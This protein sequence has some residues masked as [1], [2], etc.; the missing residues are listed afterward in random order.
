M[1]P[2]Q[3]ATQRC[4]VWC[5]RN[6]KL[7]CEHSEALKEAQNKVW[8]YC[9]DY[10]KNPSRGR[11]MVIWGSNGCGKTH[12]ARAIHTWATRCAMKLPLVAGDTMAGQLASSQ[13]M[14]WP[15]IV[16]GFKNGEWYTVEESLK[17]SMLVLDDIGAEHDPSGIGREKLYYILE[18]R[19]QRW[20]VITTNFGPTEWEMKFE[21]RIASRLLRNCQNID[22]SQV[23]DYGTL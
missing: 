6:V 21:R 16:D 5:K 14:F 13:F 22:L 3:D 11:R 23:P 20:T 18:R 12:I 15:G 19:A 9:R 17:A 10:A 7:D 2:Q 1:Q 4:R 8:E